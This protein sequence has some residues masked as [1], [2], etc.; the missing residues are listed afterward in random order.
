MRGYIHD[1]RGEDEGRRPRSPPSSA[2][3]GDPLHH[4]L[5]LA[6]VDAAVAVAVDVADHLLHRGEVPGLGEAELLEHG[7]QLGGGDEAV[8]VLVEHPERLLHVALVVVLPLLPGLLLLDG[9]EERVAERAVECL[10]V[11]EAEPRGAR[12]DVAPD[13]GLQPRAVGAEAE[14][15]ERGRHLVERDL[16]VAVA[17]EQ[18][19]HPAQ[20]QRV[21]AAVPEAERRRGLPRQRRLCG[22]ASCVHL[23]RFPWRLHLSSRGVY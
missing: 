14:R 19:E 6:E 20:P 4:A 11:A 3:H 16:A 9:A 10:E 22:D 5:E 2:P 13:R 12:G 1:T 18:V 17:V 21:Q 23:A 15:V 8:A 7:L